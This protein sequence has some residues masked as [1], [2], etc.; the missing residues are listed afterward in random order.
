[1]SIF[2]MAMQTLRAFKVM[3][4][5]RTKCQGK[6]NNR[7]S[8]KQSEMFH[9]SPLRQSHKKGNPLS[10]EKK[11]VIRMLAMTLTKR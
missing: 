8:S 5:A 11:F 2:T 3:P 1:V 4:F 9:P 6:K 10:Y 7:K